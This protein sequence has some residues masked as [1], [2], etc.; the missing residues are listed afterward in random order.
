MQLNSWKAPFKTAKLKRKR[1]YH[2]F[3][4]SPRWMKEVLRHPHFWERFAVTVSTTAM[5][6][7]A[8]STWASW[9]QVDLMRTQLTAADHNA[10]TIK[11]GTALYSA[12]GKIAEGP[13][14]TFRYVRHGTPPEKGY[15][16]PLI[17]GQ[18]TEVTVQQRTAYEDAM[19]DAAQE[20]RIF[21]MQANMF[22]SPNLLTLVPLMDAVTAH[23]DAAREVAGDYSNPHVDLE[24]LNE[25]GRSCV[26]A[27]KSFT[28]QSSGATSMGDYLEQ[29]DPQNKLP[30]HNS[31]G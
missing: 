20:I 14:K 5:V 26:D 25:L 13:V 18:E 16:V 6:I 19:F 30:G 24:R 1:W 8:A 12:C 7:S 23:L 27:T 2:R 21:W 17:G 9:H 28:V 15:I 29:V 31:G 3:M 11:I 22:P 10:I 4:W